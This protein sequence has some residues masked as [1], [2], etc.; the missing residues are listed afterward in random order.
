MLRAT[1]RQAEDPARLGGEEFLVICSNSTEEQ[2]ALG[3][4]R[5]RAAIA[6]HHIQSGTFDGQVTVSLGVAE[7]TANMSGIDALIKAADEAV[8]VAKSAGRNQVKTAALGS[9]HSKSA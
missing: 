5:I 6:A 9:K 1:T 2:A 3:A 8:Y 7:R 4:E